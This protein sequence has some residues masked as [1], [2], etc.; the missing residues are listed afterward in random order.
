[1]NIGNAII[2]KDKN[3][4]SYL[5]PEIQWEIERAISISDLDFEDAIS[6]REQWKIYPNINDR[7]IWL[8]WGI[9]F[10]R[11]FEE[12]KY[13]KAKI[14]EYKDCTI[15]EFTH[16]NWR[17]D[18]EFLDYLDNINTII[19]EHENIPIDPSSVF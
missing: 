2:I 6:K 16:Y 10:D 7:L 13:F 17:N 15:L 1:M 12:G 18:D 11:W 9:Y 4:A 3:K 19:V 8:K 5:K 14:I